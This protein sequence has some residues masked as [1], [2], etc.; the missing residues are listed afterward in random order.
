[1]KITEIAM[2]EQTIISAAV[3]LDSLFPRKLTPSFSQTASAM[4][5]GGP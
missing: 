3:D 1:V 4:T 5:L 2:S